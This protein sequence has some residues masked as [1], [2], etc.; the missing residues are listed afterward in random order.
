MQ[1]K[2][3]LIIE[4]EDFMREITGECLEEVGYNSFEA[5]NG[6][7]GVNIYKKHKDSI[8]FVLLDIE[9]PVMDGEKT[10]AELVKIN[11]N[12][13]V[14]VVTGCIDEYKIEAIK[15]IKDVL[16]LKKPY[17]LSDLRKAIGSCM[18]EGSNTTV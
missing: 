16:V 15:R 7:E 5:G 4:D 17:L 13:N 6:L 2:K 12:V 8:S 14:I 1:K 11:P 18:Q 10:L 3:A 9:M